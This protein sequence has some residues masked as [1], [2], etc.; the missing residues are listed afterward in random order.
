[1]FKQVD[2]FC[3]DLILARCMTKTHYRKTENLSGCCQNYVIQI[4][5][6]EAKCPKL[7]ESRGNQIPDKVVCNADMAEFVTFTLY[8]V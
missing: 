5:P 7:R 4:F 8:N 1:M 3:K 2:L 6:T